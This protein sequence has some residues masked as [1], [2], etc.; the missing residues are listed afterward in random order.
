A[1]LGGDEFAIVVKDLKHINNATSIAERIQNIL[2]K[3]F[4]LKGQDVFVTASIGIA[5]STSNYASIEELLR[6]ADTAMYEA[7]ASGK[8]RYTIFE[9]NIPM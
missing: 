9:P 2:T 7:K 6:D 4:Q 3:P 8:A 5:Q 1:R